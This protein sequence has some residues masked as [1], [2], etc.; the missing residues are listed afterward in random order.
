[1]DIIKKEN[2]VL[3]GIHNEKITIDLFYPK[4]AEKDPK[5]LLV[6]FH[7]LITY[8]KA[9][10]NSGKLEKNNLPQCSNV[11]SSN[12]NTIVLLLSK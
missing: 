4:S 3:D 7:G 5:P 11:F 8:L 10:F 9:S 12:N 2:I 1:M 6:F